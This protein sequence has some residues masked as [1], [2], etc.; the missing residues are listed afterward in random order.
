MPNML[1]RTRKIAGEFFSEFVAQ[2]VPKLAAALGYYTIFSFPPLLL[3]MM[4]LSDVFYGH[5]AVE[6]K[7]YQ[8]LSDLMGKQGA[9]QIQETIRQTTFSSG[10]YVAAVIG[11][12][13]LVLGATGIFAEIQ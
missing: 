10:G 12:V 7:V 4:R 8:E 11:I 9:L 1:A 3:I 2:K 5:E 13:T 6:G